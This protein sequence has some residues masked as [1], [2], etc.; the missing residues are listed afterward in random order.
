MLGIIY[1]PF[2]MENVISYGFLDM[3]GINQPIHVICDNTP[4]QEMSLVLENMK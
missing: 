4:K 3:V 2:G 1:A